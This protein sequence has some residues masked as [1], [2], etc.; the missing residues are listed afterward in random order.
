MGISPRTEIR[1]LIYKKGDKADIAIYRPISLLKILKNC[2][3]ETLDH[4]H[5]KRK[6]SLETWATPAV[7]CV[8]VE[9]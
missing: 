2:M 6:D 9:N 7:L 4:S 5:K 1:S 3:H 8:Y